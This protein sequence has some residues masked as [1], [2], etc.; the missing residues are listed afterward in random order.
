MPLLQLIGRLGLDT[1]HYESNLKK[2]E[3][4]AAAFGR[5]FQSSIV[6]TV[7]KF[8]TV[9]FGMNAFLDKINE[10]EHAF[11]RFDD[12]TRETAQSVPMLLA[13]MMEEL[14]AQQR[15]LNL[16]NQI[17][18]KQK[19]L[20]K[21]EKEL[22]EIT[23]QNNLKAMPDGERRLELLKRYQDLAEKIK[24][25][26]LSGRFN[27]EEGLKRRIEAAN[28]VGRIQQIPLPDVEAPE[29]AK[30]S[31]R[32]LFA[33]SADPL[34]RIGG[35]SGGSD[36]KVI[37]IQERIAKATEETASNTAGNSVRFR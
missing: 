12:T 22:G 18:E 2:S 17:Q 31:L 9:G 23:D 15:K 19:A 29:E 21:L 13:P 10:I 33:R 27:T 36:V 32:T 4:S 30:T 16:L 11:D 34:S 37:T 14:N 6:N 26:F 25:D 24:A 5:K 28:L 7:G 8:F 20:G 35:F 3:Q 1:S